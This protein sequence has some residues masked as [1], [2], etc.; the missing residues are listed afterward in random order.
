M[1]RWQRLKGGLVQG[2]WEETSTNSWALVGLFY[3]PFLSFPRSGGVLTGSPVHP[4]CTK[5]PPGGERRVR[6][7]AAG[8]RTAASWPP[9]SC[10]ARQPPAPSRL[11]LCLCTACLP[12][13]GGGWGGA[14]RGAGASWSPTLSLRLCFVHSRS[15][16]NMMKGWGEQSAFNSRTELEEGTVGRRW[17]GPPVTTDGRR[18]LVGGRRPRGLAES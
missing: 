13:P 15:L 6:G 12:A 3:Q 4:T 8:L 18:R 14:G 10:S 7:A 5:G 1:G 11:A 9:P 17:S 16:M 2:Y